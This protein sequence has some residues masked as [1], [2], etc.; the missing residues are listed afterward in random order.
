MTTIVWWRFFELASFCL[1]N[2]IVGKGANKIKTPFM[3]Y[4]YI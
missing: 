1:H 3:K 4:K 2:L